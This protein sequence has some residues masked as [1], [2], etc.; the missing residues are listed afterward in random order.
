M[1]TR[2]RRSFAASP[3]RTGMATWEAIVNIVAPEGSSG[4]VELVALDG[5]AASL[6]AA[7]A[8]RVSPLILAGVGPQLRIYCLHGEDAIVGDDIN[9]ESLAWSPTGGGWAMEM[10]CPPE[11]LEWLSAATAEV[12]ARV[13]VVDVTAKRALAITEAGASEPV[14]EIDKEA[15]LRG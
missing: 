2:V 8:W 14:V 7:E 15:F 11:D 6:I 13:T 9:E 5:I 10:P 12:S 1:T 3:V 4:R